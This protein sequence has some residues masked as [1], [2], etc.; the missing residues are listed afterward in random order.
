MTYTREQLEQNKRRRVQEAAEALE[1]DKL[2]PDTTE[3]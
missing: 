1:A 2:S 3:G